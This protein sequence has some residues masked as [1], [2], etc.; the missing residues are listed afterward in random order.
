MSSPN[1]NRNT[2]PTA[3]PMSST[4]YLSGTDSLYSQVSSPKLPYRPILDPPPPV[5]GL[6]ARKKSSTPRAWKVLV[7]LSI[8]LVGV[9]GVGLLVCSG[10]W[11]AWNLFI[12]PVSLEHLPEKRP[13]HLVFDPSNQLAPESHTT[14]LGKMIQLNRFFQS[15]WVLVVLPNLPSQ[16]PEVLNAMAQKTLH[17]WQLGQH[18]SSFAKRGGLLVMAHPQKNPTLKLFLS[19]EGAPPKSDLLGAHPEGLNDLVHWMPPSL[20][21]KSG[22]ENLSPEEA[23]ENMMLLVAHHYG[24]PLPPPPTLDEI[25]SQGFQVNSSQFNQ[26]QGA[27]PQANAL[28]TQ[29]D[30]ESIFAGSASSRSQSSLRLP[31]E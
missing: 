24:K 17:N 23:L 11:M 5:G 21:A 15:D 28:E 4:G 2:D 7:R 29:L 8:L 30:Q 26:P 25:Q 14:L 22:H 9:A 1:P 20:A 18:E 10:L 6:R 3:L 16:S 12:N 19:P 13:P 31:P 27:Q